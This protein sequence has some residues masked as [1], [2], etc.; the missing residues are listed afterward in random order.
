MTARLLD[1]TA[2]QYHAD[3]LSPTPTLTRTVALELLTRS[4]LHAYRI[5]PRL[6]GKAKKSTDAMDDGTVLHALTLGQPDPR[7][8]LDVDDYRTNAAKALRDQ[9]LAAGRI[10][11]K[12]KDATW[13]NTLARSFTAA[14]RNHDIDFGDMDRERTIEWD[15]QGVLCRSRLDAVGVRDGFVTIYDLKFVEDASERAITRA[16][17]EHGYDMQAHSSVRAIEEAKPEMAGRIDFVLIACEK[18]TGE[19]ALHPLGGTMREL[20]RVRWERARETWRTC[21]STSKWPGY[22]HT[23]LEAPQWALVEAGAE[24]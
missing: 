24:L 5:H 20:G 7:E 1:C 17:V 14:L 11:V 10:P 21:L 16:C 8:I 6:G 23:K 2:E 3:A 13:H 9:A 15:D 4:P 19:I 12:A 22:A 18:P